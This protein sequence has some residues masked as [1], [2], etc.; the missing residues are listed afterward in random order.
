MTTPTL[1]QA[2]ETRNAITS[3]WIAEDPSNRW[4]MLL[5]TDLA[6]WASYGV[7][8]SEELEHYLLVSNV[9]ET[10]RE[11]YGYKLNWADLMALSIEQLEGELALLQE[12][13]ETQLKHEEQHD[14]WIK[15]REEYYEEQQRQEDWLAIEGELAF[16]NGCWA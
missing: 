11:V 15:S 9:F 16:I 14:E 6:D 2:L 3:A 7:T 12:A 8:T 13:A 10:N 5:H 1:A 4:A